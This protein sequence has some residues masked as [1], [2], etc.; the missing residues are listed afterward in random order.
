MKGRNWPG[1]SKMFVLWGRETSPNLF[2]LCQVA[3]VMWQTVGWVFGTDLCPNNIWQFF[4]RCYTFFPDGESFTLSIQR[5]FAKFYT[6]DLAD[7]CWSIWNCRN[8]A[9]FQFNFLWS[10]FEI[11][12]ASCATLMSWVSLQKAGDSNS[13]RYEATLSSFRPMMHVSIARIV[14]FLIVL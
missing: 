14:G 6:I 11:V 4:A 10:L 2:F 1:N 9:T 7:F 12:F 3:R 8:R 13:L 5:P